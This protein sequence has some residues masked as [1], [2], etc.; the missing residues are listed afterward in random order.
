MGRSTMSSKKLIDKKISIF[1][2]NNKAKLR[3]LHYYPVFIVDLSKCDI[4]YAIV[5]CI[6]TCS[7]THKSNVRHCSKLYN[8]KLER[9]KY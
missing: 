6:E 7:P 3:N 4:G 9:Y 8:S 2:L 1:W 5:H